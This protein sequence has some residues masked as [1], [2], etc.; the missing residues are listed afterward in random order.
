MVNQDIHIVRNQFEGLNCDIKDILIAWL[1]DNHCEDSPN[2]L[3]FVQFQ[4]N[5]SYHSGIKQSSYM[6]LFGTE[7]RIGLRSNTLPLEVLQYLE[8][9]EQLYAAYSSVASNDTNLV[10]CTVVTNYSQP[11]TNSLDILTDCHE[12][13]YHNIGIQRNR[14][15]DGLV[16][17]SERMV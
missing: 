7:P 5:S 10:D 6:A 17:Q 3:R 16:V 1:G 8:S 12:E 13:M 11:L 9:G 14:A 4:K 2:G 15:R